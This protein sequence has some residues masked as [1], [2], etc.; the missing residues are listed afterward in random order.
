MKTG[1]T[2]TMKKTTP[3]NKPVP[4]KRERVDIL[5]RLPPVLSARSASPI[6]ADM[7]TRAFALRASTYRDSDY[8]VEGVITTEEPTRVYDWGSDRMIQE[9]LLMSGLR[10]IPAQV[11]LLDAHSQWAVDDVLGSTRDIRVEGTALVARNYF[12]SNDERAVRTAGKIKAGH[13]TDFSVG[14]RV[15]QYVTIPAGETGKVDGREWTAP[16]LSALRI[17]TEWEL[18][19]NSVVPIGADRFAKVRGKINRFQEEKAMKG[20]RKFCKTRGYDLTGATDEQRDGWMEEYLSSRSAEI[21]ADVEGEVRRNA[22]APAGDPAR[23]AVLTEADMTRILDERDRRAGEVAERRETERVEAVRS[24][25]GYYE[26]N[27]DVAA[28]QERALAER[29]PMER[30]HREVAGSVRARLDSGVG[31]PAVHLRSRRIDAR[32]LEDALVV[33]GAVASADELCA[34]TGGEEGEQRAELADQLRSTPLPD[35]VR[36]AL[37]L[38]GREVPL[39]REDMIRAGFTTTSLPTVLGN[40]AKK[41]AMRGYAASPATWRAWCN[42][43]SESDFKT[44]TKVRLSDTGDLEEV[45]IGGTV[46]DGGTAEEKETYALAR[47]AKKNIFDEI[48]II[49]DDL[50]LLTRQPMRMGTRAA[51]LISKLVYTHLLANGAMADGTELFASG[52]N[53]LVEGTSYALSKGAAALRKALETFRKQTDKDGQPIDVEPSVLL[54]CPE[55]EEYARALL[56]SIKLSEG[57]TAGLS[58]ANIWGD[59]GITPAVESRLSNTNYTGYSTTAWYLAANAAQMDTVMVA[60]L[61]GKQE[62]TVEIFK[63]LGIERFGIGYRVR[64]DAVAKALDWRGLVKVTG[65]AASS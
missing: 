62:P 12:D 30:L 20:F 15:M 2:G 51:A 33:R 37:E 19:E 7:T 63:D 14:Y 44:T 55:D 16:E 56:R 50:D 29:W 5:R 13:I 17:V 34:E 46:A 48:Q 4:A 22:P 60:F 59:M 6:A 49:N 28:L 32:A 39:N 26:G 42:I 10:E 65:V 25:C 8:S 40:V 9:V 54:A 36:M 61:N 11:P 64:I 24:F 21:R 31:A 43:G 47:Y 53:N 38:D 58:T 18:W 41:S 57:T 35:I 3:K 23:G 52:H 27:D 1:K 45:G